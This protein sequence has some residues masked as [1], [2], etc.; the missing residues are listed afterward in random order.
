[1]KVV[2]IPEGDTWLSE[3]YQVKTWEQGGLWEGNTKLFVGIS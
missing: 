2:I 3:D 1:M